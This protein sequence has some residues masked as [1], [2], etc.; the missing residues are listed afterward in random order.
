MKN[1]IELRKLFADYSYALDNILQR[2]YEW[3]KERVVKLINDI[4]NSSMQGDNGG[5]IRYNV[6]DF[7]TYNA[8]DDVRTKILFD[9][10]QR[11]TTLILLL[12]NILHHGTSKSDAIEQLLFVTKWHGCDAERVKRL[13]L[14]DGDD[15]ILSKILKTGLNNLTNEESKSC[16]ARNYK[17]I[18]SE[19]T[20]KMNQ[21]ELDEFYK[22]IMG[23]ASYFER[24]CESRQEGI[25]QFNNLNGWQQSL[26]RSRIGISSLYS[27]FRDSNS[28]DKD[29]EE[30]LCRLS[31]MSDKSAQEFLALF[32]YSKAGKDGTYKENGFSAALE[33]LSKYCDVVKE[34]TNFY[35]G[36]YNDIVNSKEKLFDHPFLNMCPLRQVYVDLYTNKYKA[37][38]VLSKEEKNRMF[39]KFEWGYIS[40]LIVRNG[41]RGGDRFNG[42]LALYS[43][44]CGDPVE[45]VVS[46]MKE[47]GVFMPSKR[48][49]DT[50]RTSK[51]D[52]F[53]KILLRVEQVYE[54][55]LGVKEPVKHQDTVTAE[56]VHP[57]RPR[58]GVE[59]GCDNTLTQTI[60]NYTLMGKNGNSANSNKPFE[61]KLKSYE[62]SPYYINSKHLSKYEKWDDNAIRNNAG[63]YILKI[64]KFYEID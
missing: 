54:D 23:N 5:S 19:F 44:E 10:Q 57:R 62:I 33:N 35:N 17:L 28:S 27:M 39:K 53:T 1:D 52:L 48:I 50:E 59:Y 14:R 29:C 63:W 43:P 51:N 3:E 37:I 11:I 30:F 31:N 24:E 13:T 60:G 25:R 26:K 58:K 47:R 15:A 20:D 12:A 21:E 32:I 16:L 55:E 46:K 45:Y 41:Q 34:A 9:G 22:S 2:P 61:D 64:K 56:H 40:N 36:T 42:I 7:I 6:G 18:S 8:E 49:L 4:R 38:S